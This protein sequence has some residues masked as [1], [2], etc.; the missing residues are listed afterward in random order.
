[1]PIAQR[2]VQI[3]AFL[4]AAIAILGGSLQIS[5]GEPDTTPRLDNIHRFLAGIYLG[6]GFICAWI[7]ITIRKQNTLVFLLCV[8]VMLGGLGRLISMQIVGIPEPVGL[9]LV[10]AGSEI[11]LPIIA[12]AAQWV[13]NR[14]AGR[15][16]EN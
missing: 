1:M 13:H 2:I 14:N 8:A 5:L 15:L 3:V 16:D 12:M 9:W 6:C 11:I 7:A 4:F 10:Y